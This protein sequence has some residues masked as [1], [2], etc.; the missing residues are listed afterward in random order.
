MNHS[1]GESTL[2]YTPITFSLIFVPSEIN[3]V[4]RF[5]REDPLL[6]KQVFRSLST[7]V[8]L[9]FE[10]KVRGLLP[11]RAKRDQVFGEPKRG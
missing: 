4:D 10:P 6:R 7:K 11:S 8:R 9:D 3:K 1:E 2:K 5:S